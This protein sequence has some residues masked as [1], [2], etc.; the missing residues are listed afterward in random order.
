MGG[1][2]VGDPVAGLEPLAADP[3]ELGTVAQEGWGQWGEHRHCKHTRGHSSPGASSA[4]SALAP[5]R[6]GGRMRA[7]HTAA[8]QGECY[9]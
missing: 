4:H 6:A 5:R 8:L 1:G 9:E 3:A 7:L 2:S